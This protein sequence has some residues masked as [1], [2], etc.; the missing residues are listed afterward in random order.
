M[1]TDDAIKARRRAREIVGE[2]RWRGM[3]VPPLY[4]D[5]AHEFENLVQSADLRGLG[6]GQAAPHQG[7]GTAA[8]S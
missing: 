7:R 3:T 8:T 2:M 4:A 6:H 5:M 1:V